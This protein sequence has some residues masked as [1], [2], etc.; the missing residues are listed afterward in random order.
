VR[1]VAKAGDWGSKLRR[2]LFKYDS[3]ALTFLEGGIEFVLYDPARVVS[4]KL[5]KVL[6][7]SAS[8]L[9]PS[10]SSSSF[11]IGTA[12]DPGWGSHSSSSS[13]S[14]SGYASETGSSGSSVSGDSSYGPATEQ[15]SALC[16][17]QLAPSLGSYTLS[18]QHSG[19]RQEANSFQLAVGASKPGLVQDLPDLALQQ[20]SPG[21]YRHGPIEQEQ[22]QQHQLCQSSSV[23]LQPQQEQAPGAQLELQ[24]QSRVGCTIEHAAWIQQGHQQPLGVENHTL[25][26]L[27]ATDK[28]AASNE[29]ALCITCF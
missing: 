4:I 3:V 17:Q 10:C 15:A 2:L 12:T 29:S 19:S 23:C 11:N 21:P 14:S 26:L 6:V 13:S 5:H 8:A 18:C 7:E 25:T 27:A 22:Q 16:C 9:L 24:E 28:A 20:G 1:H